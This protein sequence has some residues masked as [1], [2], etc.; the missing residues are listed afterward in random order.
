MV[1]EVSRTLAA[2][3]EKYDKASQVRKL[4]DSLATREAA[5]QA[6]DTAKD[7]YYLASYALGRLGLTLLR[8]SA[9]YHP[10]ETLSELKPLLE[11]WFR[12]RST[13]GEP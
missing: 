13:D 10:E 6:M 11:Q 1:D 7:E 2:I 8:Y 9:E 3:R 12:R 5:Q 4:A